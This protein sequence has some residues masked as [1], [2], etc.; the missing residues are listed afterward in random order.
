MIGLLENRGWSNL[1]TNSKEEIKECL[2]MIKQ[3][4]NNLPCARIGAVVYY[5]QKRAK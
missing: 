3:A 5:L 1:L 4:G 2:E